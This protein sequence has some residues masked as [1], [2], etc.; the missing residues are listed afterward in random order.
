MEFKKVLKNKERLNEDINTLISNFL[1]DN[2][3]LEESVSFTV[4]SNNVKLVVYLDS[5]ENTNYS[6]ETFTEMTIY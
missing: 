5:S 6:L 4:T 2:D 1:E 3:M